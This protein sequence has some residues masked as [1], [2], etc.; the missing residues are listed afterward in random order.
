[1]RDDAIDG[2][3]KKVGPPARKSLRL[4]T[5]KEKTTAN[6]GKN[7]SQSHQALKEKTPAK[8]VI[9]STHT[10]KSILKSSKIGTL[11]GRSKS[12]LFD[13]S[14]GSPVP[15]TLFRQNST[16]SHTSDVFDGPSR[17]GQQLSPRNVPIGLSTSSTQPT[18]DALSEVVSNVAANQTTDDTDASVSVA[19]SSAEVRSYEDRIE[20][21]ISSNKSK[22]SRIKELLA[23]RI[24][25]NTQ[26]ED[27]HRINHSLTVTVDMFRADAENEDPMDGTTNKLH[28][29]INQLEAEIDVF[30]GRVERLNRQIFILKD[31]NTKLKSVMS[32]HS[33]QVLSE[34][35]Y[36]L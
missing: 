5:V 28:E 18:S 6:E 1:M 8:A 27:L 3:A 25:L 31:E 22:I 10:T 19:L 21:L 36:N 33:K 16:S 4:M 20:S 23:D 2:L 35:N 26:I 7:T 29:Q 24:N 32:T 34:H 14:A 9:P 30:R 11:R 15:R 12:V 13:V 17:T